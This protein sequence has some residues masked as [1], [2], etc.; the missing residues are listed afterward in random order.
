[1]S[2]S[3]SFSLTAKLPVKNIVFA[4]AALV[5]TDEGLEYP[6]SFNESK[7]LRGSLLKLLVVI[8]VLSFCNVERYGQV[9]QVLWNT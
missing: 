2:S 1:M 3:I 8:V 7:M 6:K 5:Q 9:D 4:T